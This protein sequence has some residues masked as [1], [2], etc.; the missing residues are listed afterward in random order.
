MKPSAVRGFL[1][2]TALLSIVSAAILYLVF[3]GPYVR[4]NVQWKA[5]VDD[6]TKLPLERELGLTEG[7]EL[8]GAIWRYALVKY[9]PADIRAIVENPNIDSTAHL[10]RVR[11]RPDGPLPAGRAR[12]A[13]Q[14]GAI[15][16]L[17]V[18]LVM[19][20]TNRPGTSRWQRDPALVAILLAA[21][22]VRLYLLKTERYIHD[23]INTS[24]P[25]SE[26]I[27]FD[28]ADPHLPLRGE[29]H[30]ALPAY[31][32][33]AS[34]AMFGITA[35]GYRLLHV[36]LSLLTIVLV[37]LMARDWFG[38]VAARWA[39]ALLAFNEYY[40][41]VSSR[42]TAH[43]PH[44]LLVGAAIYAFSRFLATNR[45]RYMYLAGLFVGLAFYCKE[46]SA[47]LL[48]VFLL[49]LLFRDH[50]RWLVT[51]H[52]Y[53]AAILFALVISPDL[54]W[55]LETRS[56]PAQTTYGNQT[57]TQ[58][59]YSSHLK[60]FGGIGL[61]PYPSMFYARSA[62]QGVARAASGSE[63]RDETPEYRSVNPALGLLLVGG[64]LLTTLGSTPRDDFRRVLLIQF[65]FVFMFFTLIKPGDAPGRLDPVSWIWVESTIFAAT[66]L[67]GA[68]LAAARGTWR[69]GA[70][71]FAALTLVYAAVSV[72]ARAG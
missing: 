33:K 55:N 45:P 9:S 42:V 52:P 18:S 28:P 65:W 69:I 61:S 24:I 64:V 5:G 62:V 36:L 20:M 32:A 6:D 49:A 22:G 25:L 51:P 15:V 2:R 63:F 12:Q 53:I 72:I 31:V 3:P 39:A 37:Y 54:Y 44:L 14:R 11:F 59:N 41:G 50:R 26:T 57:V 58:A 60:R 1:L 68:R 19:L 17:L 30:P 16:G 21:L 47:L 71:G 13:L 23:E 8:N 29:N 34:S 7:R 48:P 67:A 27:S 70:R 40:L 66:M 35:P 4:V 10:D 46:H 38:S 43:V 56:E